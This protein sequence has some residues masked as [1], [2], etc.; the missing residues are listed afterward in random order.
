MLRLKDKDLKSVYNPAMTQTPDVPRVFFLSHG[1]GPLPLLGDDGHAEMVGQLKL[2]AEKIGRP[3]AILVVSAHW[4]EKVATITSGAKPPMIY[5]YYGFPKAAYEV[6]YPAPGAPELAKKV[7]E[8]LQSDGIEAELDDERGFDHGLYVPLLL[9]YPDAD[10]PCI[11]LSLQASLDAEQHVRMGAALS[12][13][14]EENILVIGSGFSFHN[15][16][17]F[18]TAP[19]D[20]TRAMNEAFEAW[21][22]DTCSNSMLSERDRLT[23]LLQWEQAPHARYCHPREEHLLPLHVCYGAAKR[24]CSEFVELSILGRKASFYFW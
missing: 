18:S 21:L 20:E 17:A 15:M 2:A 13:L 11:Q 7:C 4:E 16:R 12:G 23:R 22:I 8:V 5:D 10:I 6:Q 1:G 9:M 19:T 3:S 24:A 14:A